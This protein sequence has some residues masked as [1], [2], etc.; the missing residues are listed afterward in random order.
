MFYLESSSSADELAEP[1]PKSKEVSA[2]DISDA[3]LPA[4]ASSGKD[5]SDDLEELEKARAELQAKLAAGTK[6]LLK[7]HNLKMLQRTGPGNLVLKSP[8]FVIF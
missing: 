1:Q 3:E 5:S 8:V 2:S 6:I 4:T 7:L